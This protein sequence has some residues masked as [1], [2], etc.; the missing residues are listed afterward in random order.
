MSSSSRSRHSNYLNSFSAFVL[1]R[2][3]G[4]RSLAFVVVSLLALP[5]RAQTGICTGGMTP[6]ALNG[7]VGIAVNN[8]TK[9]SVQSASVPFV[10]NGAECLCADN[11]LGDQPL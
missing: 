8:A 1:H 2:R 11:T 7:T 3:A 4:V 5:A 9:D 10:F 6:N